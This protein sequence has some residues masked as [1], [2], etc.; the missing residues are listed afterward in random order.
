MCLQLISPVSF[1]PCT[2]ATA[3]LTRLNVTRTLYLL[4]GAALQSP[5]WT[6]ALSLSSLC[7]ASQAQRGFPFILGR[8]HLGPVASLGLRGLTHLLSPSSLGHASRRSGW[9][10]SR[11]PSWCPHSSHAGPWQ[12][13][14]WGG[15]WS[16]Q[17]VNNLSPRGLLE[18][19]TPK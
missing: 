14:M 19:V 9:E 1:F 12:E 6:Q 18:E 5:A 3:D 15:S 16:L 17:N 2:V 11:S 13:V 7:H 8:E 4:D 10:R